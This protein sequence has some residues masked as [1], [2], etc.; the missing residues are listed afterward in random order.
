MS[1]TSIIDSSAKIDKIKENEKI[2]TFQNPLL[3]GGHA[4]VVVVQVHEGVEHHGEGVSFIVDVAV[5]PR[6]QLRRGGLAHAGRAGQPQQLAWAVKQSPWGLNSDFIQM[7]KLAVFIDTKS[8]RSVGTKH[9]Y[10]ITIATLIL[11]L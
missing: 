2:G 10:W 7:N 4:G 9:I 1:A 6:Q 3:G 5:V 8:Y 11:R